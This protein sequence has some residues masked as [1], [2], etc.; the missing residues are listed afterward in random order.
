MSREGH[1]T[2]L[3]CT[4]VRHSP[5]VIT[6]A[7]RYSFAECFCFMVPEGPRWW[8][9]HLIQLVIL[10]QSYPVGSPPSQPMEQAQ[11]VGQQGIPR[12]PHIH[13]PGSVPDDN[14]QV[15]THMHAHEGT[16]QSL[17]LMGLHTLKVGVPICVDHAHCVWTI[18][19]QGYCHESEYTVNI[20]TPFDTSQFT[21]SRLR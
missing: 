2:L 8:G 5:S 1:V 9:M 12:A 6:L 13:G 19:Q 3:A 11:H 15:S 7:Y 16:D 4:E 17:S 14:R 21:L 10:H 20:G 18:G